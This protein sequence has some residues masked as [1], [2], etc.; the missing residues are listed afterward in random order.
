MNILLLGDARFGTAFDRSYARHDNWVITHIANFEPDTFED[1][2]AQKEVI[3]AIESTKYDLIISPPFSRCQMHV[4]VAKFYRNIKSKYHISIYILD[5][6]FPSIETHE[7]ELNNRDG[8][9]YITDFSTNYFENCIELPLLGVLNFDTICMHFLNG[10]CNSKNTFI[11]TFYDEYVDRVYD[12]KFK[13]GKP[14]SLR[15][16]TSLLLAKHD[17]NNSYT[18]LSYSKEP[19]HL[20]GLEEIKEDLNCNGSYLELYEKYGLSEHIDKISISTYLGAQLAPSRLDW[21]VGNVR[22]NGLGY[23]TDFN[24]YAEIYLESISSDMETMELYPDLVSFTEKSFNCFFFHKIPLAID[25][26]SNIDYLTKLGFKFPIEPMIIYPGESM[27]DIVENI[28]IWI[29]NLKK[30][31][32]KEKWNEYYFTTEF[33]N[34]PLHH[35]Y[36]II[37]DLMQTKRGQFGNTG[38]SHSIPQ[39]HATYELIKEIEPEKLVSYINWDYQKY[40]YLLEAKIILGTKEEIQRKIQLR[41]NKQ[42][43]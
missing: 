29:K 42:N 12:V 34:S 40:K 4:E 15:A 36:K 16:I 24:A 43:K 41:S 2:S 22:T 3:D 33:V 5:I 38:D 39:Y 14:K 9:T 27:E 30:I 7:V 21:K 8:F 28:D 1:I 6:L 23:T 37:T 31:N 10:E 35:N 13:I 26:Q 18:N 11:S 32:F 20:D 25:T 19:S 17:L